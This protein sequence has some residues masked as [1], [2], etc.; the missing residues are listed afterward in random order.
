MLQVMFIIWRESVEALLIVG[1]VYSWLKQLDDTRRSQGMLYL[2]MGVFL[3]VLAAIFLGLLLLNLYSWFPDNGQDYLQAVTTFIAAI[4]IVYMVYWMRTHG[5]MLKKEMQHTL[6]K[7]YHS[8]RWGIAITLMTALAIAREGSEAVVFIYALGFGQHGII[9]MNMVLALVSGFIL[10]ALTFYLFQIGQKFLSWRYF[11]KITE[12]LLLLLAAGLVNTCVDHL[13]SLEILP[14]IK[15]RIWDS[16]F[17]L[18]DQSTIGRIVASLTGYRAQ[19]ALMVL[20]VYCSYWALVYLLFRKSKKG[21]RQQS[22]KN[23]YAS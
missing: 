23:S 7:N 18:S 9:S 3:G 10:A 17:L 1:I 20:F 2:Y 11:F 4:M 8:R 6:Q 19:P 21:I 15:D 16:S 5:M 13:I 22:V 14:V 12:I